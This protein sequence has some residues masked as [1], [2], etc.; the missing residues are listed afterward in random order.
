MWG[1]AIY[2]LRR[3]LVKQ[4]ILFRSVIFFKDVAGIR[5]LTIKKK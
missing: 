5:D 3:P 1:A 4:E 2:R